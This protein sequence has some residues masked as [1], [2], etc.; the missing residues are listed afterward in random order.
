MGPPVRSAGS[1]R[2][3]LSRRRMPT[4]SPTLGRYSA[5]DA[6]RRRRRRM[7]RPL[8]RSASRLGRREAR[9]CCWPI[10]AFA[11][12][13]RR[14]GCIAWPS[15]RRRCPAWPRSRNAAAT[16]NAPKAWRFAGELDEIAASFGAHGLP[17]GFG[18]AAAEVYGRLAGFK[19]AS[20]ATLVEVIEAIRSLTVPCRGLP[21]RPSDRVLDIAVLVA[22]DSYRPVGVEGAHVDACPPSPSPATSRCERPSSPRTPARLRTRRIPCRS[23]RAIASGGVA[24]VPRESVQ[25]IARA[26][27]PVGPRPLRAESGTNPRKR[28]DD[29][30][31]AAQN[32]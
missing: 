26:L 32:P 5:R 25:S 12:G 29:F 15:G 4:S 21:F 6:R 18:R 2:L 7:Q 9:R 8:S 3:Y 13:R 27:V 11:V 28:P 16:G 17:D 31:I 19:D 23:T 20:G 14:R 1:T 22:R 24:L 30:S 10:R